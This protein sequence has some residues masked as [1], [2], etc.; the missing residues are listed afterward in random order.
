MNKDQTNLDKKIENL[1]DKERT[2]EQIEINGYKGQEPTKYGDW[3]HK[4]KVADF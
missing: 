1:L 3:Q 2:Q 4:G